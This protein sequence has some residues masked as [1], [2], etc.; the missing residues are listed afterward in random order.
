MIIPIC[1][2]PKIGV[3]PVIIPM[4]TGFSRNHAALGVPPFL[5]TSRCWWVNTA[6]MVLLVV[7]GNVASTIVK[8]PPMFFFK[9]GQIRNNKLEIW[10]IPQ[11]F[12]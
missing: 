12:W 11:G 6:Q 9:G 5:E 7:A 8:A 1:R 4:F 10:T 2:L 3:P